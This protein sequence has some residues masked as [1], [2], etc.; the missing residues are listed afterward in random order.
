M[1]LPRD[2]SGQD[3]AQALASL[4]YRLTRQTG[5]HLRLTTEQTGRGSSA[6]SWQ[7]DLALWLDSDTVSD[8]LR[9]FLRHVPDEAI[10][11]PGSRL[12]I[13]SFLHMAIEPTN[14]PHYKETQI[15]KGCDLTGHPRPDKSARSSCC[16]RISRS[17]SLPIFM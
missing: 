9:E 6:R 14:Y 4:G 11:G 1:R 7:I 16:T 2:V 8:R 13:A 3:L 17:L 12:T 10:H 5:S 15:R